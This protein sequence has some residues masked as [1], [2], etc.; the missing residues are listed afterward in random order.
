MATV[1]MRAETR[2]NLRAETLDILVIGGGVVGAGIARDAAMRGLRVGLVDRHD[3]AFGTSSRSSRLLH[4]GLRYLAQGRIGLVRE[5]SREKRVLHRIAPHLAE[6]LAFIFPSYRGSGWPLWQLRV[7]V[8][9]YDALC[10]GQN[11]GA[12]SALSVS[13]TLGKL[14]ALKR[15]G[16]SGSVRYFDGLTNDA[17][18]VLDTMRSAV[19]HGAVA[20]NYVC[21]KEAKR[22]GNEWSCQAEDALDDEVIAI[23]AR[24]LVNATGPWGDRFPHSRIS[25]RATKGI[26]LV[27]PAERMP[28]PDAVVLTEGKRILFV[29]PWGERV[30]LGTTD[31]DYQGE[32]EDVR[33]DPEDV[34]YVLETLRSSFPDSGLSESDVMS[35][36]AG[37]RPLIANKRGGPSDISRAH[38]I[39]MTE[40]GWFDVTGGKLTTYRLIAQQVVEHAVKYL[41]KKVPPSG[42]AEKSLIEAPDDLSGIVPPPVSP[43]AVK[44]Y[45][46]LEWAEHLDDIMF[47]RTSWAHYIENPDGMAEQVSKWMG[48]LRGWNAARRE[49]ELK[50]YRAAVYRPA[51]K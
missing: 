2:Q 47:R 40:P 49:S 39:R 28:V 16:L 26:H 7:G 21:L 35:S 22:E 14:P 33:C 3:F 13:D 41:G 6:P 32:P 50:R 5:A 44:H 11:L 1:S 9:I 25:L 8:K 43:E 38:Q 34:A 15:D 19:G 51:A 30:I 4:G 48:E 27:V 18:L 23:Q 45:V 31:T 46:R 20:L 24:C 17:R 42:S 29:I 10:G 36:W 12:S 37:L